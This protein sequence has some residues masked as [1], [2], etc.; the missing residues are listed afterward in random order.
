[1]T[2][3]TRSYLLAACAFAALG[4]LSAPPA[5][6]QTNAGSIAFNLAGGSL[7]DALIGLARTAKL[8]LVY[9]SRLV[10]GRT[11]PP[12]NATLPPQAALQTLLKGS[13]LVAIET[14]PG[15]LIIKPAAEE[16]GALLPASTPAGAT[17]VIEPPAADPLAAP[18]P[19]RLEE[20]VVTG[21]NI[22]GVR[23]GA[24]P[25][26]VFNRDDIDRSGYATVAE[27]LQALP[28]NFGASASPDTAQLGSD[29]RASNGA[30][31]TGVDLRGLGANATLVLVNGRRMA[32]TGSKGDFADVSAI[33]TAAISRVDVLLDGASALYGSDAV[34][35]VVNIVLLDGYDGA[36]TRARVGSAQ[37][38]ARE[39]Q[40][41]Q[42][43]GRAWDGGQVLIAYEHQ[44]RDRLAG[45]KRDYTRSADLRRFGGSDWR[46]P[47][48]VPGTIVSSSLAPL[49]AV[50]PGPEGQ[51]QFVAG[52][53]NLGEPRQGFSLIPQQDRHSV[54]TRLAL[55]LTS[56]LQFDLDGRFS[57]RRFEADG[58]PAVAAAVVTAANPHF[59]SPSGAPTQ[60]V[61]YS[62]SRELGPSRQRGVSESLGLSAG[63]SLDFGRTWRAETYAAFAQEL[64]ISRTTNLVNSAFLNEALGR[65]ADNLATSFS[66]ARDGYFNPFGSGASNNAAILQFVGSGATLVKTRGQ[67]A[68]ASLKIDGVLARSPGGDIKLAIGAQGRRESFQLGGSNFTGSASPSAIIRPLY[69]RDV[70]A[71][72]AELN[73]PI[74]GP[75]NRRPGAESLTLSLAG[76][77]E[78]YEE[79]GSTT[80]PKIGVHWSPMEGLKLR[81]TYGTSFRAPTL[82]ELFDTYAISATNLP[83]GDGSTLIA[84]FQS[85]GND[86]LAPEKATTITAGFD[87]QPSWPPKARMSLTWFDTD[88]RDRI[89]QPANEYLS[90]ALFDPSLASFVT[91]VRPGSS[92]SDRAL[93]ESFLASPAYRNPGLVPADSFGA[94]VDGRYLNTASL[95]VSG[96]DLS[97]SWRFDV[98]ANRFDLKGDATWLMDYERAIASSAPV[99]ELADTAEFPVDWRARGSLNWSRGP[100]AAST[101]ISYVDDYGAGSTRV[102]SWT[103]VDVQARWQAPDT[104]GALTGVAIAVSAQNLFDRDPPFYNAPQGVGYDPANADPLGRFISAQI[105]KR[106]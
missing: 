31:A 87:Y 81:A 20:V 75:D 46:T 63:A 77:V 30:R 86:Q 12:L 101:T 88:Y 92:A 41:A 104:S 3:S 26:V 90:R 80:D 13:G 84:L 24:S 79:A 47:Y 98:G 37:G 72:F 35:G 45:A 66:A 7:N 70:L 22:R 55:D 4:A 69:E 94:I 25:I 21:S 9:P 93:V 6:A 105:T 52:Q 83:R 61:A 95:H 54:Y 43:L 85:G 60:I 36:E 76:R 44:H 14:S 71:A 11:V 89:G 59:Q 1:M 97:A 29:P 64:A 32:G 8:Q 10:A 5:K 40:V 65:T 33:P 53:A 103:T 78:H 56:R 106:W 50:R 67:T 91:L 23:D 38:G 82:P 102:G 51:P 62:F 42:T 39:H 16:R 19:T 48:A 57:R 15:V 96:V 17:Q 58:S 27:V 99:V 18:E 28:Q 68:T 100:W 73:V 2:R 74:V 34:G 49:Y